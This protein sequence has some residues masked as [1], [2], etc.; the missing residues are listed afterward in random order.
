MLIECLRIRP[1]G[2]K[3]EFGETEYHFAPT[4]A[5][6]RHIAEVTQVDHIKRLL[7]ID[8]YRI[9]DEHIAQTLAESNALPKPAPADGSAKPL[10]DMTDDELRTLFAASLGKPAGKRK[11]ATLIAEI[12]AATTQ[13]AA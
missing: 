3:V 5:D 1:N 2:T 7:A 11:R 13:H 8:A 10:G 6:P 12:E 9:A 4:E